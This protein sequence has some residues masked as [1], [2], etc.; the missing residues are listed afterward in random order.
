MLQYDDIMI[1]LFVRFSNY[2][3][4]KRFKTRACCRPW[5]THGLGG[6]PTAHG[7]DGFDAR[8]APTVALP[9]QKAKQ[10]RLLLC[11]QCEFHDSEL[12]SMD[13]ATSSAILS[14]VPDP[15]ELFFCKVWISESLPTA[16]VV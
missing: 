5:T 15:G 13:T 1:T 9:E 4:P 6:H 16:L 12:F 14:D 10:D 2:E 3:L 11:F 7:F 8:L